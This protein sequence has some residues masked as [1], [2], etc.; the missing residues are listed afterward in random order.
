MV[1]CGGVLLGLARLRFPEAPAPVV[2][3]PPLERLA[4]RASYDALAADIQRIEPIIDDNLIVLRVEAQPPDTPRT[5]WDALATASRV[6]AVTHIAAL[7]TGPDTAIAFM[8]AADRI[9][10]VIGTSDTQPVSVLQGDP[11][12][13]WALLR[14]ATATARPLRR[15]ALADL[16]TP[17]YV[18]VVEGTQAGTTLRPVFL[19]QGTRFTSARWPR[20]LLPLGGIAIAPGAL[21]FTLD[22]E[23]VG[24]VTVEGGA[25]AVVGERDLF[26]AAA[27]LGRDTA[28][29]AG[30]IGLSVQPLTANLA[31]A[32]AVARGVVVA[33]VD[34]D[35]P[36]ASMLSPGDVITMLGDRAVDNPDD[37]LLDVAQRAPGAG[38]DLTFVRGGVAQSVT[39]PVRPA[40]PVVPAVAT[41][42][43]VRVPG[44]GTR[45]DAGRQ[46]PIPGVRVGDLVTRAGSIDAPTPA[47][48]R[49]ITGRG[50]AASFVALIVRRDGRS[51]V[52]AVPVTTAS[53]ESD[54]RQR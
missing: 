38:V 21:L 35:G 24:G 36:A 16:P 46:P 45:V 26:E 18:V 13:D 3:A 15:R 47:Q 4:A 25:P 43:L 39:I 50:A 11:V 40:V 31:Q 51:Q 19:G 8:G 9:R 53:Q 5:G 33:D 6:A 22:G 7:R 42:N 27:R 54:A 1:V 28:D 17:T 41:V 37:L 32:L 2:A 52:V 34:R 30:D 48:V 49:R 44:V 20:P 10:G 14:V 29:A 23:F 12:R